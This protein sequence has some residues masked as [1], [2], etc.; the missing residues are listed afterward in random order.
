MGNKETFGGVSEKKG[1][2]RVRGKVNLAVSRKRSVVEQ[3]GIKISTLWVQ[4]GIVQSF[5]GVLEKKDKVRGK[6][7]KREI[8]H[9][10]GTPIF[11]AKIRRRF[12]SATEAAFWDI[13]TKILILWV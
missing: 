8:S 3:N 13:V 1:K 5:G 2:V 6:D 10:D 7:E 4:R 12:L 11:L 9:R